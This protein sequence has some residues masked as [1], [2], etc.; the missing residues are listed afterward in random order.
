MNFLRLP[1]NKR[2]QKAV[3]PLYFYNTLT[4]AKE[5]FTL[6]SWGSVVRMYNCGPTVYGLQHIGNLSMFV[7][8][9]VLRRTL[10]YNGFTVKQVINFT[11][12]GHL[13]SDADEGE[14]KMTNGLKREGLALTLSNMRSLGERYGADFLE[15]L[16]KLNIDTSRIIFPRASDYIPAQIAMIQTLEE[17]GYAYRTK[18]G[19]YF[20]TPLFP[21]YGKLGQIDLSGQKAGARV[22][23]DP[24]KR[25][26]ADF[27][28]WKLNKK[29]GWDSPWGKGFP[30]WHI[31]CSAMIH[32]TLGKQIDI[33]TGGIEHIPVHHNNEIA[34]SEAATGKKPLSR[35]WLHRAHIRIDDSKIAK[36]EGNVVYLS[37]IIERGYHPL[38]LRYLFLQAHYRTPANFTW[39]ALQAAQNALSRLHSSI[40]S[41]DESGVIALLYKKRF[42]ERINDDLDTP[43]AL[44]V[45]WELLKDDILSPA[46]KRVTL[47]DFDRILGLDIVSGT[48]VEASEIHLESLPDNVRK[49]VQKREKARKNKDWK[50]AD[51]IR[52]ELE[53]MGYA[54]E[55][56]PEGPR[57]LKI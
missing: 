49:M 37:E 38:A 40:K 31:E 35:F 48:C 36:S 46:D 12:V 18:K 19:V 13:A 15:N 11:D 6:P 55:D 28:L 26:P 29:L 27:N 39:E 30:G 57:I 16:K 54:L 4:Q 1:W 7:F 56:T 22:A 25:A 20:D 14:D 34:Q 10:E 23:A 45:L 47:A 2:A 52:N 42:Q 21:E 51:V 44:A 5:E 8:T 24:E 3:K 9:D 43:G 41:T 53:Q 33:H 32:E 17:K 50:T